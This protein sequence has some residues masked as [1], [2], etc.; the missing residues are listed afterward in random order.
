MKK[1]IHHCRL[2]AL[3]AKRDWNEIEEISK[4]RKSPIG[5]EVSRSPLPRF[6]SEMLTTLRSYSHS[7]TPSCRQATPA[8][9]QPSYQ[10]VRTSN[11]VLQLRCLKNAA[12]VSRPPRK[13]SRQRMQN[14]GCACLRPRARILLREGRLRGWVLLCLRNNH[15]HI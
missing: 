9:Q 14:P 8:S 11:L 12:C 3:V 15:T 1:L 5:W 7:S 13:Q 4:T 6:K 10:N 2:R